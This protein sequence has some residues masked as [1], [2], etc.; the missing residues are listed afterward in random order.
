MSLKRNA[1]ALAVITNPQAKKTRN[2]LMGFTL[3]DKQLM[4]IVRTSN[5]F[6]VFNRF[7]KKIFILGS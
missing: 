1:D 2:E 4:E 3:K 6:N 5:K 7:L